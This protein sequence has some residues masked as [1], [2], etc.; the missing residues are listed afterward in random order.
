MRIYIFLSIIFLLIGCKKMGKE[1]GK[2]SDIK[3]TT[4]T[5]T[6]SLKDKSSNGEKL[7]GN[8][9]GKRQI[10]EKL[11]CTN[12]SCNNTANIK[13]IEKSVKSID[14]DQFIMSYREKLETLLKEFNLNKIPENKIK[15][16][17]INNLSELVNK[18]FDVTRPVTSNDIECI[19]RLG[20]NDVYKIVGRA[21]YYLLPQDRVFL[22]YKIIIDNNPP[23][24]IEIESYLSCAQITSDYVKKKEL[25]DKAI[26]FGEENNQD[27]KVAY[28]ESYTLHY[29][30]SQF[31]NNREYDKTL[32]ICDKIIK[33]DE[34]YPN[35]DWSVESRGDAYYYKIYALSFMGRIKEARE[36]YKKVIKMKMH[37]VTKKRLERETLKKRLKLSINK[38]H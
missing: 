38:K 35:E 3:I 33:V 19:K 16:P 10:N 12:N 11:S 13:Q 31:W 17:G 9:D 5:T 36:L 37:P 1:A 23:K 6:A 20:I 29:W 18:M 30:H 22:L 34:L 25:I 24:P 21:D 28:W 14:S 32:D 8:K 2:I 15:E 4:K 27:S 7:I 26:K